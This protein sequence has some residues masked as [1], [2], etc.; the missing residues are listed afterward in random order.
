MTSKNNIKIKIVLKFKNS[1]PSIFIFL[2]IFFIL[3]HNIS[4]KIIK[5]LVYKI[6]IYL[7]ETLFRF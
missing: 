1:L 2:C 7:S 5:I 4:K 6:E 3:T